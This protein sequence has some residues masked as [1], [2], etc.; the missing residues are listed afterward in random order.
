MRDKAITVRLNP[1]E[2]V[3]LV[4]AADATG[5]SQSDI[6]RQGIRHFHAQLPKPK[7]KK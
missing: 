6:V 3:M 7:K 5:L 1:D 4:E 2:F